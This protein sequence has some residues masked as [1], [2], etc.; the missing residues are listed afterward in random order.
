MDLDQLLRAAADGR[1]QVGAAA[2]NG[3][4]PGK[5]ILAAVV[6]GMALPVIAALAFGKLFFLIPSAWFASYWV[7]DA[8]LGAALTLRFA[9]LD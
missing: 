2:L 7:A 8:D 5:T 4:P 1:Q 9:A 6:A 3:Y